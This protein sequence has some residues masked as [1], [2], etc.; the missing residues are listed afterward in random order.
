MRNSQLREHQIL[1]VPCLKHV[2][3]WSHCTRRRKWH[4]RVQ[5][6]GTS[7]MSTVLLSF[8]LALTAANATVLTATGGGGSVDASY[9]DTRFFTPP[10]D[11]YCPGN[12]RPCFFD[13]T[14]TLG[15][16][17]IEHV[18]FT[19]GLSWWGGEASVY[20]S[21][22]GI[23]Q[24]VVRSGYGEGGGAGG[25]S[26]IVTFTLDDFATETLFGRVTPG[27]YKPDEPFSAFNGMNAAGDWTIT[28]GDWDV[29]DITRLGDF[30]LNVTV[31]P[32]I[33][34]WALV[35]IGLAGFGVNRPR[36]NR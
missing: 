15:A 24:H 7:V 28:V 16:G 25:S 18:T 3:A 27:T 29:G 14:V 22:N 32:E 21:H 2:L 6:Y 5:M 20:L 30:T 1:W 23:R 35:L 31:V 9:Y 33:A 4:S 10:P 8:F 26:V 13:R 17:T 11:V 12:N 36:R 19:V 34:T